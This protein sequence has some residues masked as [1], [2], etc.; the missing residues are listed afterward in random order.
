MRYKL[1]KSIVLIILVITLTFCVFGLI[2][3]SASGD[4][5]SPIGVTVVIDA[6]HGGIDGGAVGKLTNVCERD[7]NLAVAQKLQ[8]YFKNVGITVVMTRTTPLGLYGVFSPGFKNRDLKKRVEITNGCNADAFI[9]VHMNKFKDVSRR[10]AQMYYKIDDEKSQTLAKSL[11]KQLDL[12]DFDNRQSV[13]VQ[14]DF[15]VL[16]YSKTVSVLCECGFMSNPED[17]K[18]LVTDDYQSKLAYSIF[19]GTMNYLYENS[20]LKKI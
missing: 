1:G 2:K 18:L 16:N 12:V 7:V 20:S 9:S 8:E 10:G 15:Y 13:P 6:G 5:Y 3:K 19:L 11:Q 17:E 4:I 14:G